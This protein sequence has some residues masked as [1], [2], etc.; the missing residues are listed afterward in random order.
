MGRSTASGD[1]ALPRSP[2]RTATSGR[3]PPRSDRLERVA[4]D[5]AATLRVLELR[6]DGRRRTQ[7][8]GGL[9][10]RSWGRALEPARTRQLVSFGF[11]DAA[12]CALAVRTVSR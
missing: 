11:S 5:R 10:G 7:T 9:E 2:I 6:E 3:S 12:S 4:P 1:C 8:R